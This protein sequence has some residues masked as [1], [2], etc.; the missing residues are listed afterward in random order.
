MVVAALKEK[1]GRIYKDAILKKLS[2]Q[3]KSRSSLVAVNFNK[4][5][6]ADLSMLRQSLNDVD[7]RLMVTKTALFNRFLDSA[8]KT[9]FFQQ[10]NGLAALIFI[11]KDIVVP[12]KVVSDFIKEH[13]DFK[14]LGGFLED[15][16]L[17][18]ANLQEIA[19][20]PSRQQL[21]AKTVITIK[22]P[23]IRLRSTLENSMRKLLLCLVSAQQKKEKQ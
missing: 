12:L 15:K 2:S 20:L 14:F 21:V 7:A 3:Y 4:V 10:S 16:E 6:S 9:N 13:E 18:I 22:M 19:K 17:S 8:K 23:L 11:G 1:I 5:N